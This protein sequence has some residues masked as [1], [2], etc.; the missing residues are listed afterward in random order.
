ME[1]TQSVCKDLHELVI[2]YMEYK[3]QTYR[4]VPVTLGETENAFVQILNF[5][6]FKNKKIVTKNAYTLF[7]KL[8][9]TETKNKNS[10]NS[11][12]KIN[13]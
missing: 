13:K 6:D 10:M 4:L 12:R 1:I 3:K 5:N 11:N 8:K 7:M 9:N 2:P